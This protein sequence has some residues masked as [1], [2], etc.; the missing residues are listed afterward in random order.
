MKDLNPRNELYIVKNNYEN[1]Y[2]SRIDDQLNMQRY[3]LPERE[4][5]KPQYNQRIRPID[6]ANI[7]VEKLHQV[8]ELRL[9]KLDEDRY[10]SVPAPRLDSKKTKYG[11]DLEALEEMLSIK[12]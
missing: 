3:N 8:N 9:T 7:N 1:K 11:T 4:E 12:L 2:A 10:L 6:L 5:H